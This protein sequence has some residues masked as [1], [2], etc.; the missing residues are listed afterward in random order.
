MRVHTRA[1][2]RALTHKR[3]M[4]V[5]TAVT[6]TSVSL[7]QFGDAAAAKPEERSLSAAHPEVAAATAADPASA[8]MTA[9]EEQKGKKMEEADEGKETTAVAA[10]TVARPKAHAEAVR[11]ACSL[12]VS[13]V[14]AA[15]E[16]ASAAAAAAAAAAVAAA[17][18][19]AAACAVYGDMGVGVGGPEA[20]PVTGVPGLAVRRL[21]ITVSERSTDIASSLH[22][23]TMNSACVKCVWEAFVGRPWRI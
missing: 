14:R 20:P 18:A 10:R 16:T 22:G 11:G 2:A 8:A 21:M 23:Q 13:N 4:C 5:Y 15:M 12:A 1:R 17:T 7:P 6:H 3:L 9:L 19:A